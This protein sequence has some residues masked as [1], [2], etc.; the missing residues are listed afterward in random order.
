L[1]FSCAA[2]L[3]AVLFSEVRSLLLGNQP[4]WSSTTALTSALRSRRSFQRLCAVVR[5]DGIL[6]WKN[7]LSARFLTNTAH[8]LALAHLA[9][10]VE[11]TFA[12][13]IVATP[14]SIISLS[15][16]LLIASSRSV[17]RRLNQTSLS[18][19]CAQT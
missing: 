17:T 10:H 1:P 18:Q 6:L 5:L 12:H 3:E 14:R 16:C 15:N 13:K 9:Q 11:L 7:G 8:C 19:G 4:I 2:S